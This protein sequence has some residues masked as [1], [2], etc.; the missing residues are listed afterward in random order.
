MFN[1]E[2]KWFNKG[3]ALLNFVSLLAYISVIGIWDVIWKTFEYFTLETKNEMIILI[4]THFFVAFI[5]I[6]M[7]SSTTLYG[8]G[9][10]S[11]EN[12]TIEIN[13]DEK[14]EKIRIFQIKYISSIN[15]R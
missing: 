4:A 2:K 8:F 1:S 6:A 13:P 10:I 9:K 5:L 14:S 7:N 12:K 11:K 3:T 15:K